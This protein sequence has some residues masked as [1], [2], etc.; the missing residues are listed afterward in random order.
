MLRKVLNDKFKYLF[1]HNICMD[2]ELINKNS[3]LS[4]AKFFRQPTPTQQH[5]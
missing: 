5:C 4:S 3:Y 2:A 1:Q